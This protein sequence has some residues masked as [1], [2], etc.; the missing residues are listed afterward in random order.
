[1]RR[2]ETRAV[3]K[4]VLPP[5]QAR[6]FPAHQL[7]REIQEFNLSPLLLSHNSS[8]WPLPQGSTRQVRVAGW[9]SAAQR[10]RGHP[11]QGTLPMLLLPSPARFVPRGGMLHMAR[12]SPAPGAVVYLSRV[13]SSPVWEQHQPLC[14]TPAPWC[15]HSS[16]SWIY[17]RNTHCTHS[18][19]SKRFP[20]FFRGSAAGF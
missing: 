18:A 19:S 4:L 12:C 17:P 3:R 14:Y 7:H 20:M 13:S 1:M 15:S 2:T 16:P 10:E 11:C 6:K 9:Q 5:P 8:V